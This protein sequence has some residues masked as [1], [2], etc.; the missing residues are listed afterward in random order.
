MLPWKSWPATWLDVSESKPKAHELAQRFEFIAFAL[1][2]RPEKQSKRGV[3]P[4]GRWKDRATRPP[5]KTRLQKSEEKKLRLPRQL[6]LKRLLRVLSGCG[7]MGTVGWCFKRVIQLLHLSVEVEVKEIEI[8]R[9]ARAI[10]E[11]LGQG[12]TEQLTPHDL[13]EYVTSD[14]VC[15]QHARRLGIFD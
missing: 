6:I 4:M 10:G 8:C 13:W 11:V 14:E 2:L 5:P 9:T 12:V 15:L 1:D 7:G 3:A